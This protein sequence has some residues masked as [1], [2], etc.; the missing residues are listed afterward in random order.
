M[1]ARAGLVGA[2]FSR[3]MGLGGILVGSVHGSPLGGCLR[4]EEEVSALGYVF[5]QTLGGSFSKNA[6]GACECRE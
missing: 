4:R 2:R 6:A 1:E 3:G 5:H